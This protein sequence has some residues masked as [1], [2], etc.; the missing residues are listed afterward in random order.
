MTIKQLKQGEYFTKKPVEI[1]KESQVW[2]RG[3][4]DR[5]LKKYECYNFADIN[6]F[7]YIPGNK[8]VFTEFTF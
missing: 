4:Y 3:E 5:E 1:P 8:E 7:C 2:I 6:K